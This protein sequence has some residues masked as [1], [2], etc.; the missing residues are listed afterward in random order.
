M[1]STATTDEKLVTTKLARA[2]LKLIRIIAAITG[3]RQY[4]V[5]DDLVKKEYEEQMSI[6]SWY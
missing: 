3:K 5:V 6:M 4:Q 2:T 1:S